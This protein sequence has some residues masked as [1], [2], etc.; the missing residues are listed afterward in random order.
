MEIFTII[1]VLILVVC[2]GVPLYL[3]FWKKKKFLKMTKKLGSLGQIAFGIGIIALLA[4]PL[5]PYNQGNWFWERF[6]GGI[7]PIIPSTGSHISHNGETNWN[8]I[9]VT[10]KI[11]SA[12]DRADNFVDTDVDSATFVIFSGSISSASMEMFKANELTLDEF[13]IDSALIPVESG[14]AASKVCTTTGNV[15]NGGQEYLLMIGTFNAAED[16]SSPLKATFYKAVVQGANGDTKPSTVNLGAGI[17]YYFSYPDEDDFTITMLTGSYG[18]IGATTLDWSDE[19]DNKF[20]LALEMV[21]ANGEMGLQSYYDY[22]NERWYNWYVCINFNQHNATGV[23]TLAAMIPECPA[24]GGNFANNGDGLSWYIPISSPIIHTSNAY[25]NVIGYQTDGA[26][27]IMVG[28]EATQHILLSIDLASVAK[29]GTVDNSQEFRF[30]IDF[31]T[32]YSLTG[33]L[34]SGTLP[35]DATANNYHT[36]GAAT[37]YIVV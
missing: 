9:D 29:V 36:S 18:A 25:P 21:F 17:F 35:D 28:F 2:V 5:A 4:S 7:T 30:D 14:T 15:M 1:F 24:Y 16:G 3:Y 34:A 32:A 20:D 37:Y 13:L 23:S 33:M 10:F 12:Y 27:N 6:T 31:G 8:G 26:G 22:A 19:T 11:A